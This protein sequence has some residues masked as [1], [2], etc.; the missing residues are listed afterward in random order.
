MVG[1]SKRIDWITEV[2]GT[3]P[4]SWK[5][6]E[7][8]YF[9]GNSDKDIKVKRFKNTV[10]NP[11]LKKGDA[12]ELAKLEVKGYYNTIETFF[13]SESDMWMVLFYDVENM[14]K[15][16]K[17]VHLDKNGL[18]RLV[19]LSA[20]IERYPSSQDEVFVYP[21][22]KSFSWKED[23]EKYSPESGYPVSVEGF[24]NIV[25][26]PILQKED[27]IELAKI[28]VADDYNIIEVFFDSE[29][30]MW[31]VHFYWEDLCNGDKCVYLDKNG[32]TQLIVFSGDVERDSRSTYS[33][34]VEPGIGRFSWERAQEKDFA[35]GYGDPELFKNTIES[36]IAQKEDAIELAK[37]EIM[38]QYNV[39][40][41]YYDEKYDMWMV[42]FYQ[43]NVLGGEYNVYIDKNGITKL[44]LCWE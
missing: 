2:P 43:E 21:E 4:F 27:A 1:C 3:K 39:I 36:P 42:R 15:K 37:K 11:I 35:H 30:D 16:G 25:E 26:H 29:S 8:K 9:S 22:I 33:V 17:S 19:V 32:L 44:I 38:N 12:I 7:E 20:D 6:D 41:V 23:E 40:E 14:G 10:K 18:T 13:D 24:D 28:E 34:F 5:E 31:R